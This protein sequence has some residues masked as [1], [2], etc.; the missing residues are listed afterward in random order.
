MK[1]AYSHNASQTMEHIIKFFLCLIKVIHSKTQIF[2][3][4]YTTECLYLHVNSHVLYHTH[5]N[6]DWARLPLVHYIL[7]KHQEWDKMNREPQSLCKH[8]GNMWYFTCT[9]CHE[10]SFYMTYL[11]LTAHNER[12]SLVWHET[13]RTIEVNEIP[14]RLCCI[15]LL[16]IKI[17]DSNDEAIQMG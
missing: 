14:I 1:N 13:E 17:I 11:C 4:L 2:N 6:V 10:D 12:K 8:H 7:Y 15:A 16:L 5:H 9:I 3:S